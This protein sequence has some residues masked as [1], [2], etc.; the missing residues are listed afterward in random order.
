MSLELPA[1]SSIKLL[2]AASP[3]VAADGMS[4]GMEAELHKIDRH[5]AKAYHS[6]SRPHW[7]LILDLRY[8]ESSKVPPGCGFGNVGLVLMCCDDTSAR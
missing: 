8:L 7:M 3:G 5:G 1:T 6:T 4:F 2:N